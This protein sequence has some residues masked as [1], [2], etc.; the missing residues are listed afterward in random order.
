AEEQT[1]QHEDPLHALSSKI[2]GLRQTPTSR[3]NNLKLGAGKRG[4]A[5]RLTSIGGTRCG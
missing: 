2:K 1:G 4:A 3:L 5:T